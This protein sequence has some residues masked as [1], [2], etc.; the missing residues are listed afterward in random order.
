LEETRDELLFYKTRYGLVKAEN[1]KLKSDLESEQTAKRLNTALK[2]KTE[3]VYKQYDYT[4]IE[5]RL[6]DREKSGAGEAGGSGDASQRFSAT[7]ALR[8]ELEE[9]GEIKRPP[10][11]EIREPT[12]NNTLSYSHTSDA[13]GDIIGKKF[14]SFADKM[15][16]PINEL[17]RHSQRNRNE[18]SVDY[19]NQGYDPSQVSVNWQQAVST[20]ENR[21]NQPQD[22]GSYYRT[23]SSQGIKPPV[24]LSAYNG[25]PGGIQTGQPDPSHYI[26]EGSP[27]PPI[28][29]SIALS[30]RT[31]G[32]VDSRSQVTRSQNSQVIKKFVMFDKKSQ[33]QKE[34]YLLVD[35][36]GKP[37][38]DTNGNPLIYNGPLPH[39]S[40]SQSKMPKVLN[41]T[42][43]SGVS[44]S[45]SR[46]EV[47]S[48]DKSGSSR[49]PLQFKI[50]PTTLQAK[51]EGSVG[52]LSPSSNRP[53]VS[54]NFAQK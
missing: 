8:K 36:N 7:R 35:D 39:M 2:M 31:L 51:K 17:A 49:N 50:D 28:A 26:R 1:A 5:T 34:V 11:P 48:L 12:D 52:S 18:V 41:S 32:S 27:S 30:N 25:Y 16:R 23:Q 3:P 46:R 21:S 19:S 29:P 24:D 45:M 47:P 14:E 33:A 15:G 43:A 22:P 38:V 44:G 40:N 54:D 4:D 53:T 37:V 6:K 42:V 20:T 9:K 10:I 13:R